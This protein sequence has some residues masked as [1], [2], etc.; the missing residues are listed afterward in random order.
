MAAASSEN[1][2]KAKLIRCLARRE[3]SVRELQ[4]KFQAEFDPQSLDQA[5]ADLVRQGL[6]SD[7]RYAEMLIRSRVRQG[8]GPA[9][10]YA[11]LKLKGVT[12]DLV[13]Q[14]LQ[15]SPQDWYE[16]AQAALWRRF[17]ANSA[18]DD[19]KLRA[20][21]TR[22]LQYRGFEHDHIQNALITSDTSQ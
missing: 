7:L 3:Y 21:K 15:E 2:I 1:D 13:Q 8:Y 16:L 9:R 20:K 14:A 5:L 11:E 12:A 18:E 17:G 22:F 6:Q 4:T 19:F 10:I